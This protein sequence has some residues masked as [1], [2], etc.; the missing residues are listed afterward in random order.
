MLTPQ[1]SP[2]A[3]FFF[4]EFFFFFG[5]TYTL[6]LLIYIYIYIYFPQRSF[7]YRSLFLSLSLSHHSCCSA[8]HYS[9]RLRKTPRLLL[10]TP[11]T[12]LQ[13][14]PQENTTTAA[15][16]TTDTATTTASG[17]HH[18]CCS[19]AATT[20]NP[21]SK[22]EDE[23]LGRRRKFVNVEALTIDNTK[24]LITTVLSI[25]HITKIWISLFAYSN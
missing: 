11:L 1:F 25:S 15:P 3:F 6:R 22:D 9:H 4:A 21:C 13:P 5:W 20:G 18:D 17:K 8:H 19:A 14:L 7:F 24:T 23:T 12:P 2:S 10:R 16:H